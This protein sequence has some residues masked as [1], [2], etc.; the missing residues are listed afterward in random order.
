MLFR[1]ITR[2]T[3]EGLVTDKIYP[4]REVPSEVQALGVSSIE[5]GTQTVW[6]QIASQFSGQIFLLDQSGAVV[7]E[8]IADVDRVGSLTD[9][10]RLCESDR[11]GLKSALEIR[12][13][14]LKGTE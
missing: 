9:A 7:A 11:K 13:T 10:L 5:V 8:T 6:P 3:A 1:S 4:G 14:D 2:Q 12:K